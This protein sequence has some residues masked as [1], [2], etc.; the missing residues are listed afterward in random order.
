MKTIQHFERLLSDV[1]RGYMSAIYYNMLLCEAIEC[2]YNPDTAF[3][4]ERLA[5]Q[6]A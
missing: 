5:A 2:C 6:E 3:E 4:L 1:K